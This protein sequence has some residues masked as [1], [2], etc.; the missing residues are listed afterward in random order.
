M[1]EKGK[2]WGRCE[3]EVSLAT[4]DSENQLKFKIN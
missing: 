1:Q 3:W 4:I 2:Q